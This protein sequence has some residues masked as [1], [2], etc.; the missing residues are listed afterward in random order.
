M[1]HTVV[2]AAW[3]SLPPLLRGSQRGRIDRTPHLAPGV[4]DEAS[5]LADNP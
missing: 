5:E 2:R 4:R 1:S 3:P